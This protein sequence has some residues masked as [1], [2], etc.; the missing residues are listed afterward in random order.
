MIVDQVRKHTSQGTEDFLLLNLLLI[1]D[2]YAHHAFTTSNTPDY[3]VGVVMSITVGGQS[4]PWTS[5]S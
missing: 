5:G 4:P 3:F 1:A 2:N